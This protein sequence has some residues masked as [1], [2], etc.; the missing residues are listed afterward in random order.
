M[1]IPDGYLS[2]GAAAA[3]WVIAALYLYFAA[4]RTPRELFPKIAATAAGIFIAQM[5]NWPIPG[6]TSLHFVGGAFAAIY[7]GPWAASIAL[8]LVLAV[9]L[10]FF[11]DGGATTYG[12][13]VINMGIIDVW[14]GYALW[15]IIE[16]SPLSDRAKIVVG[17]FLAGWLGITA[18]GTMAGV[19]IGLWPTIGYPLSVTVPAMFFPHL[20]LGL[21]EGAITATILLALRRYKAWDITVRA[22]VKL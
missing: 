17:G 16:R 6:G 2:P 1:H 8:A 20:L 3:T 14:V 18:A 9:Q 22:P 11:H 19:E 15:R 7:M 5:L 10:I 13:N 12:A 21:V 4:R